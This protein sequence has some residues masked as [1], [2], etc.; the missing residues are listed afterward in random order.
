MRETPKNKNRL[1]CKLVAREIRKFWLS[2]CSRLRRRPCG[3]Y[4][5]TSPPFSQVRKQPRRRRLRQPNRPLDRDRVRAVER[6]ENTKAIPGP[7][8]GRKR[9]L[10]RHFLNANLR[11][12]LL[13][14]T[15]HVP[16]HGPPCR[17]CRHAR[18]DGVVVLGKVREGVSFGTKV[19]I[20]TSSIRRGRPISRARTR[21]F[22][23]ISTPFKS[24]RGVAL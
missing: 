5:S 19:S 22:C 4:H 24:F 10:E 15:P 7:T 1:I 17:C 23:A 18:G 20:L 14:N 16:K 2:C 11:L 13:I 12:T 3:P 8:D 21:S 9:V 6:R